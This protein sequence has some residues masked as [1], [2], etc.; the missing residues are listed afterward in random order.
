MKG[1]LIYP[2]VLLSMFLTSLVAILLTSIDFPT[3]LT[4][5]AV[6]G[7]YLG[8]WASYIHWFLSKKK[9]DSS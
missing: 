2:L 7:I 9:D 5:T 3:Y 8:I 1:D 6:I 4:I